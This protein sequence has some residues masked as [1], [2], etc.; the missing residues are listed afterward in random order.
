METDCEI[1]SW[2]IL[3]LP[4]ILEE[5]FA[6]RSGSV[7]RALDWDRR[8]VFQASPPAES[9]CLSMSKTPY[10]LLSTGLTQEDPSGN[11]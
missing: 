3:L 7:G 2:V 5:L 9:L 11:D 6:E 10:P 1:V 8:V 4:L